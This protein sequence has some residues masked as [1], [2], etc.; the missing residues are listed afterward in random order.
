[1]GGLYIV[2]YNVIEVESRS[3]GEK[4]IDF[5]IFSW[6]SHTHK[7]LKNLNCI[8]N[9]VPST[10]PRV[11][12][13]IRPSPSL[14]NS[15]NTWVSNIRLFLGKNERKNVCAQN[16]LWLIHIRSIYG[17]SVCSLYINQNSRMI[18]NLPSFS[19]S[20]P[21]VKLSPNC[22]KKQKNREPERAII[23]YDEQDTSIVQIGNLLY[24]KG[25]D[26]VFILTGGLKRFAEVCRIGRILWKLGRMFIC[27]CTYIFVFFL[28]ICSFGV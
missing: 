6:N 7:I 2:T 26:N 10:T 16:C 23:L 28:F 14:Q 8:Y 21:I 15:S 4:G 17:I 13:G 22:T 1:M 18:V 25:V 9:R 19:N 3:K 27:T 5:E 20:H 24:E 12:S 11:Y